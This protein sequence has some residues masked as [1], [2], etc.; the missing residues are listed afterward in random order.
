LFVSSV[1]PC[2]LLLTLRSAAD[3]F[4]AANSDF[5]YAKMPFFFGAGMCMVTGAPLPSVGSSCPFATWQHGLALQHSKMLAE[6]L[7]MPGG[8]SLWPACKILLLTNGT[9]LM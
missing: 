2:V 4:D 9:Q 7:F 3:F 8:R 6:V 5:F 1:A